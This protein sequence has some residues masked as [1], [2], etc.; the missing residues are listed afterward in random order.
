MTRRSR[1]NL[2]RVP[3]PRVSSV[4]EYIASKPKESRASLEAVRRAIRTALPDAQEGLL[5]LFVPRTGPREAIIGVVGALQFDVIEARMASEYAIPCKVDPLSYI[6]ARWPVPSDREL[7]LPYSGAV[8][9]IDRQQ[10]DALLFASE[11]ALTYTIEQNPDVRFH[12]AL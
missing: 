5:Q 10:R 2:T 8:Q 4:R 9:V 1:R 11:W 7:K 6:A 12:D 3:R